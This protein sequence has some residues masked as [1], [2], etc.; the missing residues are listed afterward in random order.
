M[1]IL[2]PRI[3]DLRLSV[4]EVSL[5]VPPLARAWRGDPKGHIGIMDAFFYIVKGECFLKIE[6]KSCV[7]K[8]GDLAFLPKG[9]M[10][11]YT[12]ISEDFGL[13]E[14][15]FSAKTGEKDLFPFLG[16][17]EG[18]A[19]CPCPEKTKKLFESSLRYEHNKSGLFDIKALSNL[20]AIIEEY[21][22]LRAEAESRQEP[23]SE[24]VEYMRK[25]TQKKI[26][27]QEL[28]KLSFMQPTYFIKKFRE[29]YGASPMEYCASL[30]LYEAMSL[31]AGGYE[32]IDAVAKAVGFS[33]SAYFSRFF[34]KHTGLSPIEYRA[35]FK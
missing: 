12:R 5:Y 31:L 24:V 13:Y 28:A 14:I 23:F 4:E 27:L 25:N 1:E 15:L 16:I 17:Y 2:L 9:R 6:D 19:V 30:K 33:D 20:A 22:V 8:A 35:I 29:A 32:K 11:T 34:K 26:T 7:L 3:K 10:R 18:G 21:I